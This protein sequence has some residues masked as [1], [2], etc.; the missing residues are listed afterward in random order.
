MELETK[1]FSK[2]DNGFICANCGAE[3]EPLGKTSRNHC[4]YC[5]CSLHVDILPGDRANPCGGIMDAVKVE[6]D[7]RKGYVILHRCRKCGEICRNRAAYGP[8]FSG[9]L[10]DLRKLIALTAGR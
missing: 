4:P 10:D 2:N 5:L 1:R 8:G 9:Q 3:V 7:P 6:T